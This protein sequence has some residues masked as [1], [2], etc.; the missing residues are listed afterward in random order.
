VAPFS[1]EKPVTIVF[2][3]YNMSQPSDNLGDYRSIAHVQLQVLAGYFA[4]H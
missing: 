4:P 2:A 3:R 1:H